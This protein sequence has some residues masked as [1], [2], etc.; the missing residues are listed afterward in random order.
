[1]IQIGNKIYNLCE[2]GDWLIC[3]KIKSGI[4]GFYIQWYQ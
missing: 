4:D 3:G 2:T 1:M